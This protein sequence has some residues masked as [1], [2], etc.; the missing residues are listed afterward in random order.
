MTTHEDSD[1]DKEIYRVVCWKHGDSRDVHRVDR[2]Q[3]QMCISDIATV[4]GT[5]ERGVLMK[6]A[7]SGGTRRMTHLKSI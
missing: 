2:R 5:L 4:Y 3:R 6:L 1:D 7:P